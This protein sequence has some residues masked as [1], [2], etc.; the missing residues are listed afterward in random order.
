MRRPSQLFLCLLLALPAAVVGG[1][2]QPWDSKLRQQLKGGEE[3]N[4]INQ[5]NLPGDN[6]EKEV[7]PGPSLEELLKVRNVSGD[8]ASMD[9]VYEEERGCYIRDIEDVAEL[10]W[11][12]AEIAKKE[13]WKGDPIL[14]F[15][16]EKGNA[17]KFETLKTSGLK[18]LDG[19]AIAVLKAA[20]DYIKNT[21]GDDDGYYYVFAK[22]EYHD[23]ALRYA[24][25]KNLD[26]DN[27]LERIV[28]I[29]KKKWSKSTKQTV[30]KKQ[31]MLGMTREQA[32][33]AWGSPYKINESVG[34]YGKHEQWVY[35]NDYLY[36]INGN[37]SSW[38]SSR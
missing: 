34:L 19:M 20:Y 26:P 36:F 11:E 22:F 38:Q 13:D 33:L 21:C 15:Y 25:P 35:E 32:R 23:I 30:L 4:V 24:D 10:Y 16:V 3:K 27:D 6:K 7:E 14:S 12:N 9:T 2:V 1:E 17:V 18:K 28:L 8:T 31:I 29:Q 37:L 5:E